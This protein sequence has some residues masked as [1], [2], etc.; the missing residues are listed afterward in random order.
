M[1]AN[2]E[3]TFGGL[4]RRQQCEAATL[5]LAGALSTGLAIAMLVGAVVIDTRGIPSMTEAHIS[6]GGDVALPLKPVA[7]TDTRN[8]I[9]ADAA[10]AVGDA[11][12]RTSSR[13]RSS[14]AFPSTR[15]STPVAR[16]DTGRSRFA[17]LLLGDGGRHTVRP[18][19]VVDASSDAR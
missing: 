2:S 18:F 7:S 4:S 12:T 11:A 1:P 6:H 5:I 9:D 13:R 3:L 17:R 8:A 19:P 16:P 14:V 10:P 15:R